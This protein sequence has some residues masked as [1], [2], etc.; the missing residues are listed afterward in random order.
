VP[1]RHSFSV[2]ASRKPAITIAYYCNAILLSS[3]RAVGVASNGAFPDTTWS[4]FGSRARVAEVLQ[5]QAAIHAADDPSFAQRSGNP[6]RSADWGKRGRMKL[7]S[8]GSNAPC[9]AS[10]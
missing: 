1:D 3:V 4:H 9:S 2:S 6:C 5:S 10:R 8:A 7:R